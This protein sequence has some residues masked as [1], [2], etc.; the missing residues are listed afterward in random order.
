MK[1]GTQVKRSHSYR[2]GLR[3]GFQHAR[4]AD[5][6]IDRSP[7]AEDAASIGVPGGEDVSEYREGYADGIARFHAGRRSPNL[8]VRY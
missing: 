3:N 4:Y 7:T 8:H 1:G 5:E 2:L 6:T